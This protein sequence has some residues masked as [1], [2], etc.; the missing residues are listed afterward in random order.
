MPRRW[1]LAGLSGMA[2]RRPQ[3][4]VDRRPVRVLTCG[5]PDQGVGSGTAHGPGI[6]I[7]VKSAGA[8]ISRYSMSGE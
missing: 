6:E 4:A 1:R 2:R 8:A 5:G 3:R 7:V